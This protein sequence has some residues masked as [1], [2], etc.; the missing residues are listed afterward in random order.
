[1]HMAWRSL[2]DGE[3]LSAAER[4]GFDVFLTADAGIPKNHD[5]AGWHLAVVV[6]PTKRRRII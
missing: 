1:M 3:L 4:E 5:F 6:I 2:K